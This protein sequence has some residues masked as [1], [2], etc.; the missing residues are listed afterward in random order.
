[1]PA[2]SEEM[3][4]DAVDR[5]DSPIGEVKRSE[6][7][8]ERLNFRVVHILLFNGRGEL[9]VQQLANDRTRH[10]R[11][12]GSSVA[13]YLFAGES[14]EAAAQRRLSQELGVFNS[15]LAPVGKTSM[16]D[17]GCLKFIG[18]FSAVS[19]GPF[20]FDGEHISALEFVSL[21]EIHKLHNQGSVAFTPTFIRVLDFYENWR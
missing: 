4:I 14:Y 8:K 12:W 1:M 18:V 19:E 16:S 5:R 11:Y 13:G 17:E 21:P 3:I 6:V 20:S 9:L 15:R 7:F 2:V 10:P